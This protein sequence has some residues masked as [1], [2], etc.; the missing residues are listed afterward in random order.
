MDLLDRK[1]ESAKIFDDAKVN[2]YKHE[3]NKIE[4]KVKI[5][6]INID[7]TNRNDLL[8]HTFY[9]S[10]ILNTYI[11]CIKNRF[12]HNFFYHLWVGS[13]HANIDFVYFSSQIFFRVHYIDEKWVFMNPFVS[14]ICVEQIKWK[15]P[16]DFLLLLN[17]D[18]TT[19]TKHCTTF[20]FID[21]FEVFLLGI[22]MAWLVL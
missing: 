14:S 20:L 19:H 17:I 6:T 21:Q 5:Y 4:W 2:S 12:H 18:L 13:V 10:S 9:Q 22:F 1:R 16:V 11:D 3:P 7:E 8:W 15:N